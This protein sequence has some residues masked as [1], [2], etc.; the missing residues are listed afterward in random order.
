MAAMSGMTF[1]LDTPH[2][3]MM[4][5]IAQ[6]ERNV[7]SVTGKIRPCGRQGAGARNSAASPGQRP[8]SDR[9][10]R[11]LGISKNTVADIVKRHR[12]N[13]YRRFSPPTGLDPWRGSVRGCLWYIMAIDR[14]RGAPHGAA[15]PT[16][17]GIRVRT[18]AVRPAEGDR[19]E[20]ADAHRV[21][22]LPAP[23]QHPLAFAKLER[24]KGP[25]C[26][27]D[28]PQMADSFPA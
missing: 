25:I 26:Q 20:G 8:N 4:A 5:G 12:A 17:P 22:V 18:T 10:A 13:P 19:I 11:D 24:F 27:L 2:G 16:P 3:R 21:V 14:D 6:F 15:P 9:L 1:E 7:F 28:H 23:N